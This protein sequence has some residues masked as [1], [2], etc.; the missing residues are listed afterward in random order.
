MTKLRNRNYSSKRKNRREA[1]PG[2]TKKCRMCG[3]AIGQRATDCL[4]G[5]GLQGGQRKNRQKPLWT[6][7]PDCKIGLR[8]H[9]RALR[10]N[11]RTLRKICSGASVHI[12]I[13]ELLK[14][15][16]A[17]VPVP[18]SLISAVAG[19]RSW[20]SRLRELRQPPFG[21]KISA[22]RHKGSSGRVRCDYALLEDRPWPKGS[23]R[24]PT[25]GDAGNAPLPP[26]KAP[27]RH[28]YPPRSA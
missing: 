21:W 3:W 26:R 28:E 27:V 12:R 15:I 7:C 9:F 18:S 10:V 14:T 19:Q 1:D 13:G 23:E 24:T 20:K 25:G 11:A 17:G 16:G 8:A 6:T 2:P 22:L 4:S 5:S